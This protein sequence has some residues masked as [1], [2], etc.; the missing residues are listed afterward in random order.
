MEGCG[1]TAALGPGREVQLA[2]DPQHERI[3]A[4]AQRLGH[5]AA[6]RRPDGSPFPIGIGSEP[7]K[8]VALNVEQPEVAGQSRGIGLLE[9]DA[10]P[11]G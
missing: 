10:G 11:V 4:R 8:N 9:N 2:W 3:D 5:A 6:V 1:E 7:G